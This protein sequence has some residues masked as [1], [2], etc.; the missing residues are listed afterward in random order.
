MAEL[1]ERYQNASTEVKLRV[2]K[3]IERGRVGAA[4]KKANG[5]KCQLCEA[6]NHAPLGFRK[7]NGDHYV[8]AH[9]VMP[10]SSRQK[11]VLGASNIMT[12]CA[13]HHRHVHYGDVEIVI[14]ATD[15]SAAIDGVVLSIPRLV[16]P[17]GDPLNVEQSDA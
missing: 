2:S 11:G 5:Y 7:R 12:L 8:E 17:T 6:M 10:V 4:V 3:S 15:F 14:S 13:N 9:H 16:L 1:E